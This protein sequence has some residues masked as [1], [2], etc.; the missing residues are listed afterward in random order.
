MD[1][2]LNFLQ[3]D[4]LHL[5]GVIILLVICAGF[6]QKKNLATVNIV[7]SWKTLIVSFVFCA[8][9]IIL[10]LLAGHLKKDKLVDYFLSFAVA[11]SMYDLILKPVVKKLF[12]DQNS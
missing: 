4:S 9:Y 11:T 7:D 5:D 6:W 10:L 1:S 2:I 12:P 8:V 3:W